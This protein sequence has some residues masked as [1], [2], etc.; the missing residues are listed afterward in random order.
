MY[1]LFKIIIWIECVLFIDIKVLVLIIFCLILVLISLIILLY[2][3][4]L[5]VI[6]LSLLIVKWFLWFIIIFFVEDFLLNKLIEKVLFG[7]II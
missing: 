7:L 1:V 4:L 6:G 2:C 3:I 5:I